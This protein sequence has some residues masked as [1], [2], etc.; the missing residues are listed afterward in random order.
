MYCFGAIVYTLTKDRFRLQ[1]AA[2]SPLNVLIC[3]VQVHDARML[4]EGFEKALFSEYVCACAEMQ[5]PEN[6][7]FICLCTSKKHYEILFLHLEWYTE[8]VVF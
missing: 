2:Y 4:T 6:P 1:N 5:S 3:A 8:C 7:F